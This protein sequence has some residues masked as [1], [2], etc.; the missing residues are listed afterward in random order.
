MF[1][2]LLT[3]LVAGGGYLWFQHQRFE[4]STD[5]LRHETIATPAGSGGAQLPDIVRA[6]ALRAGGTPGG[7]AAIHLRHRAQLA[8]AAGRPPMP[9]EADQW[10]ATGQSNF[11]WLAGG[12]MFGLPVSVLDS[13]VDGAG[14]LDA[15]LVGAVQMAG[16][17]GPEFDRGEVQRYL[18]ELPL[19]PD[20]ILNN[21]ELAWRQLSETSV[22]VSAPTGSRPASVRFILDA[23]GDI[24]AMEAD[25]RPMTVGNTTVP[26]PWRGTYGAYKRFGRYRI[27]SYGEVGWVLPEGL[28]IYWRGEVTAYEPV[29]GPAADRSPE[30]RQ[31]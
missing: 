5:A 1:A 14:R 22:E 31:Q 15:R 24:V 3:A 20:A 25:D 6:Y 9:I 4:A 11:V 23:A 2:I 27:P 17:S 28:S 30:P 18:S 16:G 26:T 21:T 8:T 10:L 13:F 12:S 29:F 7:P 19:H